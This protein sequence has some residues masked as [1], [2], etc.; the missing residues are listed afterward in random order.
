MG[1]NMCIPNNFFLGEPMTFAQRVPDTCSFGSMRSNKIE[2]HNSIELEQGTTLGRFRNVLQLC[3]YDLGHKHM[4]YRIV[5][6]IKVYISLMIGNHY[7]FCRVFSI[8]I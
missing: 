8:M 1:A 3:N 5:E 7:V 6:N 4:F 2:E